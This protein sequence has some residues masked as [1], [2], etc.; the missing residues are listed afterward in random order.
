MALQSVVGTSDYSQCDIIHRNAVDWVDCRG[1]YV[2]KTRTA[3]WARI[4]LQRRR[5]KSAM[6]GNEAVPAVL[7]RAWEAIL[8]STISIS[9]QRRARRRVARRSKATQW[10]EHWGRI[11]DPAVM[12]HVHREHKG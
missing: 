4:N 7:P 6:R 3:N 12:A 8:S 11:S 5:S 1:Q 2:Q 9:G 10:P